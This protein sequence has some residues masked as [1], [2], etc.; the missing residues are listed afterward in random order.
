MRAENI[1]I[2]LNV[3]PKLSQ[4]SATSRVTV[5]ATEALLNRIEEWRRQQPKIPTKSEAARMLI[6]QA[7]D[8]AE[9]RGGRK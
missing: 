9:K 4:L 6:E 5:I 2:G 1:V 7:L 8:A 3:P